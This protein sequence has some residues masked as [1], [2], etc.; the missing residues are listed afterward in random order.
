VIFL[1]RFLF[2]DPTSFNFKLKFLSYYTLSLRRDV[3]EYQSPFYGQD[4]SPILGVQ[5]KHITFITLM[6]TLVNVEL[7]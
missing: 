6:L 7:V 4:P 2:V 5:A 3:T 1:K